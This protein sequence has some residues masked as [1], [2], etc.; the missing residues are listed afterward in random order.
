MRLFG[1]GG[2]TAAGLNN[3]LERE[4]EYGLIAGF[5]GL[6]EILRGVVLFFQFL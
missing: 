2:G 5:E 4:Q 6:S 1:Y 3:I